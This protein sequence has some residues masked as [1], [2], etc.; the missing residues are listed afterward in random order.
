MFT[1]SRWQSAKIRSRG[2][3]V[4]VLQQD[5]L[6]PGDALGQQAPP[7]PPRSTR[8]PAWGNA[9]AAPAGS[10]SSAPAA[11]SATAS[12]SAR[13]WTSLLSRL[14]PPPTAARPPQQRRSGTRSGRS[15][16]SSPSGHKPP[17]RPPRGPS[18][19][20]NGHGAVR[21]VRP[22]HVHRIAPKGRAIQGQAALRQRRPQLFQPAGPHRAR[23]TA[24][25]EARTVLG[26]YRSAQA[27]T[28]NNPSA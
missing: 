7:P 5:R 22:P 14:S 18:L 8:P 23:N 28:K 10:G 3:A 19:A 15:S 1:F 27:F 24:P 12:I 11:P 20:A 6:L 25:M 17:A 26:L 4:L 16:G 2:S 9:A 13:T 21:E